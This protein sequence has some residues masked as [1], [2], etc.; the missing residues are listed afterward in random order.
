MVRTL[1]TPIKG[2]WHIPPQLLEIYYTRD[3]GS[4]L[5]VADFG[6]EGVADLVE[7]GGADFE[8]AA[9]E[10]P[11]ELTTWL[12]GEGADFGEEG[13]LVEATSRSSSFQIS[14][15]LVTW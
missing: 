3:I 7:G 5:V 14:F 13:V 9:K 4:L 10:T 6:E 1:F 8:L 2:G 11:V 12:Q 15:L